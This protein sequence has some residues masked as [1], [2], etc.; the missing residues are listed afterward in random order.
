MHAL[1]ERQ[2]GQMTLL[3]VG[4]LDVSRITCGRPRLKRE[5]VDLCEVVR[6]A[7]ETL[8]SGFIQRQQRIAV[9]WP[10]VPV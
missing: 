9:A 6:A 7:I 3:A 10:D 4:L 1:I 5:R 2:V 8:E